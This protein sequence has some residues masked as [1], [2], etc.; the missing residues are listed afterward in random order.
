MNGHGCV[1]IKPVQN[2][3]TEQMG[4]SGYGGS[5]PILEEKGISDSCF[6]HLFYTPHILAI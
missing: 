6:P 1:L 5:T 4:L 2:T 3:V